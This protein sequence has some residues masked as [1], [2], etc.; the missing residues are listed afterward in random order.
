ML[1]AR[2]LKCC[3][4]LG[5]SP[6]CLS[7]LQR[8]DPIGGGPCLRGPCNQQCSYP[9]GGGP[10]RLIP[11]PGSYSRGPERRECAL[12]SAA[13]S[14]DSL[15]G[16]Q[17]SSSGARGLPS[18]LVD[19]GSGALRRVRRC[20]LSLVDDLDGSEA[21]ETVMFALGG[22]SYELDLTTEHAANLR[23]IFGPYIGAARKVAVS[24]LRSTR[25]ERGGGRQ[26]EVEPAAVRAWA[27]ENEI[28]VS[29]V[30]AYPKT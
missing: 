17:G 9:I 25:T 13:D 23:G 14:F 11:P 20:P 21:A 1:G 22:Q 12:P 28:R 29:P 10:L 19:C 4:P 5:S 2:S 24:T 16:L 30:A 15:F 27:A 7:E 26:R 8:S 6:S 3:G 18:L